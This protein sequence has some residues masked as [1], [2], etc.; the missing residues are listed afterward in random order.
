MVTVIATKACSKCQ[1]VKPL[2]EFSRDKNKP[3][4]RQHNCKACFALHHRANRKKIAER[5]RAYYQAN[6]DKYAERQRGWR[7]T[8]RERAKTLDVVYYHRRRARIA[9]AVPQRWQK[10]ECSEQLCYWCGVDLS[11]VV[12]ETEHLMPISLGGEAKPYN[13]APACRDCNRSKKDKHPLVWIA[14]L[15][16]T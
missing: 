10:S 1:L 11:T 2:D 9:H 3:D 13:E 8:N 4:G 14:H 7:E 15:V 12:V 5:K 16:T 6:K